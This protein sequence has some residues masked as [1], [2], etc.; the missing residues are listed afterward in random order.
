MALVLN[1]SA[2][3]I[4]GLAVGGLPDGSVDADTLAANAVTSGKLASG[5]GGKVLQ[6]LQDVKTDDYSANSSGST[7]YTVTGLEQAITLAS[8]SNKVLVQVQ[9]HTDN[10]TSGYNGIHWWINRTTSGSDNKLH[11]GEQIG[12]NRNRGTGSSGKATTAVHPYSDSAVFLDTPGSVGAHTYNIKWKDGNAD[13]GTLY[14][15]RGSNDSDA[16]SHTICI[17]SITLTEIAA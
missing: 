3:T 5:V 2:N 14:I 12:S 1:G 15:N 13:G 7:I 6:V 11:V 8:A 17:S 16:T 4:G 10:Y 9:L